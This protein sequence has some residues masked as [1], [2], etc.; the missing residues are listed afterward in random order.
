MHQ[1][2]HTQTHTHTRTY[3][4]VHSETPSFWED[5]P[6]ATHFVNTLY[7]VSY[8]LWQV[9]VVVLVILSMLTVDFRGKWLKLVWIWNRQM[10]DH[11]LQF[12]PKGVDYK[13]S[14]SLPLCVF[15]LCLLFLISVVNTCGRVEMYPGFSV[16]IYGE[17]HSFVFSMWH[18]VG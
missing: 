1:L 15:F 9:C 10:Q 18:S 11:L 3:I 8:F 2:V 5:C 14:C 16:F 12:L 13:N 7:I 4:H 17:Q 6:Y